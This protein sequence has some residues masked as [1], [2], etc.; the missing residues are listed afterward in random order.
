MTVKPL[1]RAYFILI[2]HNYKT[3]TTQTHT[4]PATT[5]WESSATNRPTTTTSINPMHGASATA[6]RTY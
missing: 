6:A 3:T 4:S 2:L 1:K 5:T